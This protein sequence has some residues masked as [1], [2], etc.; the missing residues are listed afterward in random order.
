MIVLYICAKISLAY[1]WYYLAHSVVCVRLLHMWYNEPHIIGT[2]MWQM[3]GRKC[4]R[5]IVQNGPMYGTEVW[6]MSGAKVWQ[7]YGTKV[8]QMY[9]RKCGITCEI[10]TAL[11]SGGLTSLWAPPRLRAGRCSGFGTRTM[12]I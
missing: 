8:W 3:Y 1:M 7:T 11:V 12:M 9:G 5:C 10:V 6:Q 4:G 2:C